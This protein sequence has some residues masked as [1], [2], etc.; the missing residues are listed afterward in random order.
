MTTPEDTPLHRKL[1]VYLLCP[2]L[3]THILDCYPICSYDIFLYFRGWFSGTAIPFLWILCM[4]LDLLAW[5]FSLTNIARLFGR[6]A[7][8]FILR[9]VPTNGKYFFPDNDCVRQIDHIRGY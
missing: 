1:M 4:F 5:V 6:I 8:H 2:S 7:V 3:P 9:T